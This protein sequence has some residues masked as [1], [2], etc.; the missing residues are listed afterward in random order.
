MSLKRKGWGL[1]KKKYEGKLT[2]Q[3]KKDEEKKVDLKEENNRNLIDKKTDEKAY[4]VYLYCIPCIKFHAF[5]VLQFP[6]K[7][8][9]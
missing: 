6:L 4:I 5:R 3:K 7:R 9:K 8:R 2:S 1:K